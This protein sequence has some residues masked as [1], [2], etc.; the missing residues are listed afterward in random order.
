MHGYTRV[1][2]RAAA[3]F[4]P[5]G[6]VLGISIPIGASL[7]QY[8]TIVWNST[9][10]AEYFLFALFFS[11]IF[12]ALMAFLCEKRVQIYEKCRFTIKKPLLD[13]GYN[14]LFVLWALCFLCFIPAFLAYY[15]GI[16][17]YD[18]P[19][20]IAPLAKWRISAD[21][22]MLH[23]S[24]VAAF[25]VLGKLISSYTL[26]LALFS[27]FQML[28]LSFALARAADFLFR[29]Q[30][31]AGALLLVIFYALSPVN[32]IFSVNA[33]KDVLYSILFLLAVTSAAEL[34]FFTDAFLKSKR[35]MIF[36][37]LTIA[38]A[39]L[40]KANGEAVMLT[41]C[42]AL[43][44][45]FKKP[46]VRKKVLSLAVSSLALFFCVQFFF[47]AIVDML[48]RTKTETMSVPLQQVFRVVKFHYDELSEEEIHTLTEFLP[49]QY[50]LNYTPRLADDIKNQLYPGAYEA[51]KKDFWRLWLS[52][53]ERY[54]DEYTEAFLSLNLGCWYPGLQYPDARTYHKYIETWIHAPDSP[55]TA[56]KVP[57][58]FSVFPKTLD[59]FYLQRTVKWP[60][61]YDF[62]ENF[63]NGK[64]VLNRLPFA[65]LFTPAGGFYA[66]WILLAISVYAKN[67]KLLL[68]SAPVAVIWLLN[69]FS[70]IAL[71]RYAY[72]MLLAMPFLCVLFFYETPEKNAAEAV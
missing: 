28:L 36:F 9:R 45:F 1:I 35:K 24:I 51:H 58:D 40:M 22:P 7:D 62:Y 6:F 42:A 56:V 72:P 69:M 46:V 32:A 5:F 25:L 43:I 60:A 20:Q 44:L 67:H 26:G 61:A 10:L 29:L 54:P 53:G 55:D 17:A 19:T 12:A 66:L 4:V 47:C 64:T 71:L 30:C 38:A 52:L 33:V 50:L 70:P 34:L 41:L 31:D 39:A 23:T 16:F 48:P 15:P 68:L 63:G 11:L 3:V 49:E 8:D 18:V 27:V 13:R 37:G 57:D 14:R 59:G 21:H 65:F 2:V